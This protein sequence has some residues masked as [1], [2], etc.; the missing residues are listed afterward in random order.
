MKIIPTSEKERRLLSIGLE[1]IEVRKRRFIPFS[2][3]S[4]YYGLN[5]KS[6]ISAHLMALHH[7]NLKFEHHTNEKSE[8]IIT[9]SEMALYI[10]EPEFMMNAQTELQEP[11]WMND[12]NEQQLLG[13]FAK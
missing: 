6:I 2:R 13:I 3:L 12:K 9:Y 7:L 10:S 11:E 5:H 1:A 8:T 4:K